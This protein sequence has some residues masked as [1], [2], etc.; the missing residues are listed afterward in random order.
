VSDVIASSGVPLDEGAI[1][2]ILSESLRGLNYLHSV[3]KVRTR[4]HG[5]E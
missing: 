4:W 1:A 5:C 3:G 2:C